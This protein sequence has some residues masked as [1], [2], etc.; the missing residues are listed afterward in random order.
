MKKR[1]NRYVQIRNA[2]IG[3]V[4][5][6]AVVGLWYGY[7]MYRERTAQT[8][9]QELLKNAAAAGTDPVETAASAEET[10]AYTRV[11]YCDE[12]FYQIMSQARKQLI[13]N[14]DGT[15]TWQGKTYRRNTYIKAIVGMGVDRGDEMTDTQTYGG[16]GQS[17]AVFLLVRDT[18]RDTIKILMIPRDSIT[19]VSLMGLNGIEDER[20]LTHLNMSYAF[21]DGREQSCENVQASVEYLLC[22]LKIDSYL[23]VDHAVL[24][25]L[26]DAV[27]GVTV[28]IPTEGMEKTD[29][30]FVKGTQVTLQGEQAER[31]VRFRDTTEDNSALYR[32]DQHE[33]Y[34]LQFF[35]ALKIKSREDSQIVTHLFDLI[36][37]YMV[38]DMAKADY[39]KIGA[40]ALTGGLTSADILTLP[41]N[42]M[43]GGQFDEFYV[44]YNNVI[45]LILNLFYRE[46]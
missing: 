39:L 1:R 35:Q 10:P 45:P 12:N 29:P 36:Q 32:M 24:A 41:G 18:A 22:G 20:S 8:A 38:T 16:S 13:Y 9:E 37:D 46:V 11:D 42:G 43:A 6:G 2:L 15:L 21:G 25:M 14:A 7:G 33:E 34:I 19:P 28:T 26:N 44:D 30:A 23:A 5:T 3:I 27:G 31:F 40:D 4:M 17:D